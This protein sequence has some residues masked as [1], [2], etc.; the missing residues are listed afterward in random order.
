MSDVRI[1]L[2]NKNKN[3]K[4]RICNRCKKRVHIDKFRFRNKSLGIRHKQCGP[5]DDE[6]ENAKKYQYGATK[7]CIACGFEKPTEKFW[8]KNKNTGKRESK[9]GTCIREGRSKKQIARRKATDKAWRNSERGKAVRKAW[10]E[11]HKEQRNEDHRKR[12]REDASYRT[13]CLVRNRIYN[14]LR[15]ANC[16]KTNKIGYLGISVYHYKKWLE[17]QFDENMTWENQGTYWHIDHVIPCVIFDFTQEECIYHCFDWKNTRPLEKNE[18]MAKGDTV[19]MNL[20]KKHKNVVHDFILS[21]SLKG[22][23][24]DNKRHS[25]YSYES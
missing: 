2:P 1:K 7:I 20:I 22:E 9:C 6:V 14:C 15:D 8:Y 17:F 13:Q 16:R 12:C 5:C 18:N 21:K 24:V 10:Y 4:F 25:F 19:D 3:D 11:S 23:V